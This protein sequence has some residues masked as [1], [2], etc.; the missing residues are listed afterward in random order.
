MGGE[1]RRAWGTD[2]RRGRSKPNTPPKKRKEKNQNHPL[3]QQ[4][5]H[6][7]C[8]STHFGTVT[9]GATP[10]HKRHCNVD[11]LLTR[12]VFGRIQVVARDSARDLRTGALAATECVDRHHGEEARRPNTIHP[13]D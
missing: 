12:A 11:W 3:S 6:D 5:N 9:G 8:S 7:K 13:V 1:A 10:L 2:G 4:G